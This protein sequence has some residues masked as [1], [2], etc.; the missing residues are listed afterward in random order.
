MCVCV[1][2]RDCV[3]TFMHVCVCRKSKAENPGILQSVCEYINIK[4]C[5]WYTIEKGTY[6]AIPS[7]WYSLSYTVQFSWTTNKKNKWFQEST[8]ITSHLIHSLS[9]SL[10]C[11]PS[12]FSSI[13][14]PLLRALTLPLLFASAPKRAAPSSPSH[15]VPLLCLILSLSCCHLA[16][17]P[18]MKRFITPP[19]S[20]HF[21]SFTPSFQSPHLS[22]FL[23][24]YYLYL[25]LWL[26]WQRVSVEKNC[27]CTAQV[28]K[29]QQVHTVLA[30]KCL[31]LTH[32]HRHG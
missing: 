1:C 16:L 25:P 15:P 4:I 12:H 17:Q 30:R 3:H 32:I 14:S 13:P 22:W 8:Y 20:Q 5:Y 28:P 2:V 18:M 31:T 27:T 26:W 10:H 7:H 21:Y 11:M 29:H 6:T 23:S 24:F 19:H 9:F